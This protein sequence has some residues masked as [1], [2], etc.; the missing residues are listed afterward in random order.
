MRRRRRPAEQRRSRNKNSQ[1]RP[2]ML[3]GLQMNTPL[4]VSSLIDHA[5]IFHPDAEV[6][7]RTIE[8]DV[9]R[10]NYGETGRRTKRLAKALLRQG[11]APGDRIGSLAWNTHR[12]FEMFYGVS[13][14]GAV[15]HTINPRLFPEQLV[16]IINHAEDRMLFVDAATLPVLEQIAPRLT[17]VRQWVMMAPRE[18]MPAKSA[19]G[20]LLCYD[21]LL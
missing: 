14:M 10:T 21:E 7:A 9:H 12:H 1:G 2:K 15:L 13:G 4:A 6:V 5:A 11:V 8:G 3:E 18:R 17:T 19:V 20:D 16:Y